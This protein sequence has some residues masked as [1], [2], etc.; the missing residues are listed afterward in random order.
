MVAFSTN[1]V[2]LKYSNTT[3]SS[4]I[5]IYKN[6]QRCKTLGLHVA[7][8][9]PSKLW[10]RQRIA[11]KKKCLKTDTTCSLLKTRWL[12]T[13]MIKACRHLVLFVDLDFYSPLS[14][15]WATVNFVAS[16]ITQ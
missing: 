10:K 11:N 5:Y 1:C 12:T 15:S 6:R 14:N 16:G 4:Q 2:S 3:C 8:N 13:L 9:V 7:L